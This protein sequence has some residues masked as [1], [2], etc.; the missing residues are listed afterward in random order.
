MAD[1]DYLGHPDT[2]TASVSINDG[3]CRGWG[4]KMTDRGYA[5]VQKTNGNIGGQ[6]LIISGLT[7]GNYRFEWYNVWSS[8]ASPIQVND[9]VTVD[10]DGVL[11]YE[12]QLLVIP[13]LAQD[14]IAL[15]FISLG[16]TAAVVSSFDADSQGGR[17][18]VKWR[19]ASEA[20]T[21]G[22]YLLRRDKPGGKFEKVNQRLLPGLLN[23]PQGGVYRLV[24]PQARPGM[25]YTYRL[26]EVETR[27]SKRSYGP[28]QVTAKEKGGEGKPVPGRGGPDYSRRAHRVPG[29]PGPLLRALRFG[30][31][32]AQGWLRA[33]G[34]PHRE[35]A[36]RLA[37]ATRARRAIPQAKAAVKIAVKEQ[38]LYYLDASEIARPLEIPAREIGPIIRRRLLSLSCQGRPVAYLPAEGN[39]GIYFYGQRIDSIYTDENIYWLKPA[40]GVLMREVGESG[41]EPA[42]EFATFADTVHAE[43]N[44]FPATALF[45]DPEGDFWIWAYISSGTPGMSNRSFSIR[46]EDAAVMGRATLVVHLKGATNTDAEPDHHAVVSL[47]GTAIGEARWDATD[48]CTLAIPFRQELLAEGANT[49]SVEGVL[50]TGAPYSVFYVDSFDLTYQRHYEAV[51]NR[52]LCRADDN[53]VISIRG[54]TDPRVFVLD[55]TAPRKPTLV[56]ATI[57][58]DIDG[59]YRVSLTPDGPDSLYLALTPEAA[60]TPASVRIDV[61][62]RLKW[63]GTVRP[64]S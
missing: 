39:A 46:A 38:G 50:D 10:E 40:R 28:F 5:W 23:A 43:Q 30:R 58:E 8:G 25:T 62:S 18:V 36:K 59:G 53:P 22:F 57:I 56:H 54:F 4:M 48:A 49:V 45:N 9:P 52:L 35:D 11:R 63:G 7:P 42:I 20:G 14:D 21:A 51:E 47:N 19:T 44:H 24:D 1:I 26:V 64:A 31:G 33:L 27:G 61:P 3:N 55:V 37:A 41:I 29:A 60:R 16:A 13:S 15:K 2:T 12:E 6:T 32:R 34:V 17:V